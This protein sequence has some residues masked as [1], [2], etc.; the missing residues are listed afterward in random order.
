MN[1]LIVKKNVIVIKFVELAFKRVSLFM[2]FDQ[3][4]KKFG[5]EIYNLQES[6]FETPVFFDVE[7]VK[8][9]LNTVGK[10]EKLERH[11]LVFKK[12]FL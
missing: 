5:A 11:L 2:V 3:L 8:S 9:Y 12:T 7:K 1:K 10:I 4:N 6:R